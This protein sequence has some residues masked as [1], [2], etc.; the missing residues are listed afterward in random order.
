[1]RADT[2]LLTWTRSLPFN[3]L[4]L[5]HI[6][7]RN[8]AYLGICFIASKRGIFISTFRKVSKISFSC[9]ASASFFDCT[10]LWGKGRGIG[11]SSSLC[12]IC[13]SFSFFFSG[14]FSNFFSESLLISASLTA[15][16][17][18]SSLGGILGSSNFFP[19]LKVI[20]HKL[21]FGFGIVCDG[22]WLDPCDCTALKE[23]AS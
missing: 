18:S 22:S 4:L 19:D 12:W 1:M 7:L 14:C 8:L 5:V 6:S 10:I 3:L 23:E 15:P 20:A 9:D 11:G 21:A 2:F 13:F 16:L 17:V